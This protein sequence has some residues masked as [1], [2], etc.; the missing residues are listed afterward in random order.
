LIACSI[1]VVLGACAGCPSC[2]AADH[3]LSSAETGQVREFINRLDC[4][5]S[6]TA[7]EQRRCE[8]VRQ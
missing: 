2:V 3:S 8:F 1:A 7:G 6:E 4:W 5:S